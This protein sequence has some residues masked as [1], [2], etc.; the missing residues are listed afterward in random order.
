MYRFDFTPQTGDLGYAA[1]WLPSR[2]QHERMADELISLM[3][4][5]V[6]G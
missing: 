2:Q 5:I 4:T 3:R 1:G 6:N